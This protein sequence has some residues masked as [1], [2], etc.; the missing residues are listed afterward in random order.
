MCTQ[1]KRL[2]EESPNLLSC[3]SGLLLGSSGF[4]GVSALSLFI[5]AIALK[6]M[7]AN[8][9]YFCKCNSLQKYLNTGHW[10]EKR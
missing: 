7:A 4:L 9:D 3:F 8:F 1:L 6:N 5:T 10:D 2:W